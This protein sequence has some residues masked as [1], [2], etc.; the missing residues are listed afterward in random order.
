MRRGLWTGYFLLI[1]LILVTLEV[2]ARWVA[3][4]PCALL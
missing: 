3:G 1:F 4:H 2:A